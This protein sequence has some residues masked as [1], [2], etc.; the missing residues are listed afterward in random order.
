[1]TLIDLNALLLH[2]EF[3]ERRCE[4]IRSRITSDGVIRHPLIAATDHGKASHL[5]LDGVNRFEALRRLGCR[6][7]PIQEVGLFDP[8]LGL[9]TWNH[10]VEGLS[11]N[12]V[13]DTLGS[14][15][16]VVAFDGAFTQAGDFIPRYEG[17]WGAIIVLPDRRS[18]AVVAEGSMQQRVQNIRRMVRLLSPCGAMDRVSYTNTGDLMRNYPS[19]SALVC[20]KGFSKQDVLDLAMEGVLFPSGVTRFSVPKR[21]LSFGFPIPLLMSGRLNERRD[22]VDRMIVDKIQH[23][24]IRFYEE[25]TFHFDD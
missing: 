23:R 24:K 21:A 16:R 9:S 2:E 3:D 14:S 18:L 20:Y 17:N 5:L 19:F 4:A 15:M 1:V 12:E 10:E 6:F 25:P 7:V 11:A 22:E 8:G 13:L